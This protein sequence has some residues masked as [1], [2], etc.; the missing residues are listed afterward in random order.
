MVS[1]AEYTAM[2]RKMMKIGFIS[3]SGRM[4]SMLKV[5]KCYDGIFPTEIGSDIASRLKTGITTGTNTGQPIYMMGG[6]KNPLD[7]MRYVCSHS[8]VD[9]SQVKVK[10]GESTVHPVAQLGSYSGKLLMVLGCV[11]LMRC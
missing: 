1:K 3:K 2:S 4:N 9:N 10:E 5:Y 11:P 6:G 8:V 7:V